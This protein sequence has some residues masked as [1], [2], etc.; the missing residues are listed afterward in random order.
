MTIQIGD[1]VM[2]KGKEK[3]IVKSFNESGVYVVFNC[4][5]DWDNFLNYTAAFCKI[6]DLKKGWSNH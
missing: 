5:E 3:E 4:G 6:E 2:Y 1:K